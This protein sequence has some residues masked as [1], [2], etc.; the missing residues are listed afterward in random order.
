MNKNK[1]QP[2]PTIPTNVWITF[3]V[4]SKAGT[5]TASTLTFGTMTASKSIFADLRAS[6]LKRKGGEE[7]GLG[8]S[9][10]V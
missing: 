5:L 10:L 8:R 2:D 1:C 4:S 9:T 7:G 6:T 3:P